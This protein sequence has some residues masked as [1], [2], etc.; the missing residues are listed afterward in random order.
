MN[1]WFSTIMIN[2][3]KMDDCAWPVLPTRWPFIFS[4]MPNISSIE[5]ESRWIQKLSSNETA[6]SVL[7][8]KRI[9]MNCD[10]TLKFIFN[11]VTGVQFRLLMLIFSI[12]PMWIQINCTLEI[13]PILQ[14]KS[15]TI[16]L[17][18][19]LC[20]QSSIWRLM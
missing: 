4:A 2:L 13:S 18:G 14:I 1:Y 17:K 11:S 9:T 12:I 6:M 16:V 3:I 15:I 5:E 8:L 10:S 20:E 7:H 19:L